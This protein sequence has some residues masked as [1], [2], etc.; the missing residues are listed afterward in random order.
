VHLLGVDPHRRRAKGLAHRAAVQRVLGAAHHEEAARKEPREVVLP[1]AAGGEEPLAVE[2]H[3]LVGLGAEE[4][5][6]LLEERR[7]AVH[8]PEARVHP[9]GEIRLAREDLQGVPEHRRTE[10]SRQ[11]REGLA[12]RATP[13][14]VPPQRIDHRGS[15]SRAERARSTSEGV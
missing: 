12:P 11:V 2:Q 3:A 13:V 5:H 4:H 14:G 6:V 15:S 1:A 8:E 9:A 7:R 10:V